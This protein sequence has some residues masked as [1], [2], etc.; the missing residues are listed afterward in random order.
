MHFLH[1]ICLV[2]KTWWEFAFS[3]VWGGVTK[4][5]HFFQIDKGRKPSCTFDRRQTHLIY[6][7]WN[8]NNIYL[9]LECIEAGVCVFLFIFFFLSFWIDSSWYV[10]QRVF[11]WML[12]F[13]IVRSKQ[14]QNG[15]NSHCCI[16]CVCVLFFLF[17]MLSCV[18]LSF[19][20]VLRSMFNKSGL[21]RAYFRQ[22]ASFT[23][24]FVLTCT[25]NWFYL[26]H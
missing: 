3:L 25:H 21:S 18:S 11:M 5:E 23:A 8:H 24:Y 26:T 12:T 10:E 9:C 13:V 14:S 20:I 17:A 15:I 7:N 16:W 1:C 6:R 2:K 22:S 4:K 19:E